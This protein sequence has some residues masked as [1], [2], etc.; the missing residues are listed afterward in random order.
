MSTFVTLAHAPSDAVRAA[1]IAVALA[2]YGYAVETSAK[3]RA[4][5]AR[6]VLLWSVSAARTPAL[7]NAARRALARG[8]LTVVRLDRANAPA[9]LGGARAMRLPQGAGDE[10][11]WRRALAVPAPGCREAALMAQSSRRAGAG[12]AL[13]LAL[14]VGAAI[15]AGDAAFAA[16]VNAIA[17][18]AQ[19]HASEWV[20]EIKARVA[21]DG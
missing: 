2:A 9:S 10:V 4:G 13:M 11:F 7:R 6:L 5:A 17:G 18:I 21:R 14:I 8:A 16:R 15:Y 3:P 20:D 19:A 1:E 12:A